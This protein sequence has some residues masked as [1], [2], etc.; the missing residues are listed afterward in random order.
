MLG[1]DADS[2][3]AALLNRLCDWC[4]K[5]AWNEFVDRYDPHIRRHCR[6][7]HFDPETTDELCQRIWIDLARRM[8]SFRYDP[9]RTFRGWLRSLRYLCAIDLKRMRRAKTLVA[10]DAQ[11]GAIE[12]AAHD[13]E[14]SPAAGRPRLLQLG[15][16]VQDAVRQRVSGQTWQIFWSIGVEGKSIRE[17]ADAA[18]LSYVAT[19]AAQKRVGQMLRKEGERRLNEGN[20]R[21]V[22]SGPSGT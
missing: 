4:D 13:D 18:G 21:Q 8:R 6:R 19:F 16:E 15:G 17:T 11:I 12:Q 5:E 1:D 9:G 7:F 2:T 22:Q 14:E 10:L 20:E 3:S